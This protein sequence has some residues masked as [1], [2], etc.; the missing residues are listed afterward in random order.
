MTNDPDDQ[1]V[2]ISPT[3]GKIDDLQSAA[4]EHRHTQEQEPPHGEP[5]PYDEDDV[6][7]GPTLGSIDELRFA[8]HAHHPDAPRPDAPHSEQGNDEPPAQQ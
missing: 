4:E 3:L 8:H 2:A 6:T 1:D 7:G 5:A